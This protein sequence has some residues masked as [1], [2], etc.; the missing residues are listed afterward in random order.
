ML[1][2]QPMGVITSKDSNVGLLPDHHVNVAQCFAI[3]YCLFSRMLDFHKHNIK[4]IFIAWHYESD[5]AEKIQQFFVN[6]NRVELGYRAS[7]P[8]LRF[9]L[10]AFS[11][12]ALADKLQVIK[13]LIQPYLV[14]E[15]DQTA[16]LQLQRYIS[17]SKLAL[18]LFDQVTFGRWATALISEQ[19]ASCITFN[20]Q[21]LHLAMPL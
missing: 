18:A 12:A 2:A 4:H 5:L 13:P 6:D 16:S 7:F 21:S 10:H 8:Y 20:H 3:K 11:K 17:A 19:T 15:T 14:S 1:T 9:K